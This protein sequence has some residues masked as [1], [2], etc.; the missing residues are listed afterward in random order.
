MRTTDISKTNIAIV[1]YATFFFILPFPPLWWDFS[2]IPQ[3]LPRISFP[4]FF[5]PFY[6]IEISVYFLPK[7]YTIFIKFIIFVANNHIFS[8][9]SL[10]GGITEVFIRAFEKANIWIRSRFVGIISIGQLWFVSRKIKPF[11]AMSSCASC[12]SK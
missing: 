7:W 3:L 1:I 5:F 11:P 4:I 2:W 8:R 12:S 10:C 6:L 9:S